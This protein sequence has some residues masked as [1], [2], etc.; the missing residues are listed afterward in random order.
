MYRDREELLRR[1]EDGLSAVSSW[2]SARRAAG[3]ERVERLHARLE[4]VRQEIRNEAVQSARD[5]LAR[6]RVAIDEMD[7]DDDAPPPPRALRREELQS[8]RRH[9]ELTARLLPRLSN[10][11]DPSWRSAHAEYERSWGELT[12]AFEGGASRPSP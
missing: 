8:L 4:S 12:R 2:L 5:A 11:D 9:L 3:G 7:R 1:M 10:L 6:A